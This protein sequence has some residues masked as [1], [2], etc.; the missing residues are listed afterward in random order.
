MALL[1]T[2]PCSTEQAEVRGESD[3][4]ERGA[5]IREGGA[6]RRRRVAR[7]VE[8]DRDVHAG[9]NAVPEDERATEVHEDLMLDDGALLVAARVVEDERLVAPVADETDRRAQMSAE[10]ERVEDEPV[11]ATLGGVEAIERESL[12]LGVRRL[13]GEEDG[14]RDANRD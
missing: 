3:V 2:S 12:S 10:V 4:A 14:D 13:A 9:A 1:K 7:L 11:A 6:L 8:R 5:R